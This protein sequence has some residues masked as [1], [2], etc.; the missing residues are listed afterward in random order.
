MRCRAS[1][2]SG[3]AALRHSAQNNVLGSR[4]AGGKSRIASSWNLKPRG[5]DFTACVCVDEGDKR[6]KSERFLH[7]AKKK[8][9]LPCCVRGLEEHFGLAGVVPDNEPDV[10]CA[11]L[12]QSV[13]QPPKAVGPVPVLADMVR[14]GKGKRESGREMSSLQSFSETNSMD[15]KRLSP[16]TL[17]H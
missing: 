6:G 2:S 8:T 13:L 1:R 12:P 14:L 5:R 3:S 15:L 17:A 4:H 9:H 16:R 11:R 10:A 7:S